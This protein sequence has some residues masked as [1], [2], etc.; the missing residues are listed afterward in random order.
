MEPQGRR[1]DGS[2]VVG[3]SERAVVEAERLAVGEDGSGAITGGR[4]PVQGSARLATS[5]EVIRELR[6][7]VVRPLFPQRLE[8]ASDQAVDEHA[9]LLWHCLVNGF[10]KQ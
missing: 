1:C 2:R 5:V 9:P 3:Q 6:A 4:R 8:H 7:H 10:V